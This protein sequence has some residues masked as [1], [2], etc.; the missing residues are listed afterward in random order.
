MSELEIMAWWT[1]NPSLS[2][3][4]AVEILIQRALGD[5]SMT[6]KVLDGL[7]ADGKASHESYILGSDHILWLEPE[8][9][10]ALAPFIAAARSKSG[11]SDLIPLLSSGIQKLFLLHAGREGKNCWINKTPEIIRFQPELRMIFGP[12]KIIHLI[13]DGRDVVNSSVKLKWWPLEKGARSWRLLIEDTRAQASLHPEDYLELRYE[14]F[15]A[16]H[17]GT[18]KR[19]FDF[20]DIEGDAEEFVA[21]Q[22]RYRLAKSSGSEPGSRFPDRHAQMPESDKEVFKSIA[23]DLLIELGYEKNAEW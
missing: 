8:A 17:V 4:E 19:V 6:Q 21:M 3:D 11:N 20:L 18:L 5:I 9:L 14:E 10:D 1:D 7:A 12:L 2:A 15:I 23:N 13:R 22:R 16:D